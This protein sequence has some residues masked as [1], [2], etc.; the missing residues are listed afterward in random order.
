LT[1][2][3]EFDRRP[4]DI[5]FGSTTVSSSKRN[6]EL[7]RAGASLSVT[8]RFDADHLQLARA[9]QD[10][11]HARLQRR[12][13]RHGGSRGAKPCGCTRWSDGY[14]KMA[15]RCWTAIVAAMNLVWGKG[16]NAADNAALDLTVTGLSLADWKPSWAIAASAIW[17]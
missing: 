13:C 16:K 17:D 14:T 8:G 1:A 3:V 15:T 5:D 11:A 4:A 12:L 6:I 10:D 9:G 7:T 2:A